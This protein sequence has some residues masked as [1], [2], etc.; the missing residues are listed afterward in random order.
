MS[1]RTILSTDG[2]TEVCPRSLK[3]GAFPSPRRISTYEREEKGIERREAN[4]IPIAQIGGH[5]SAKI[6]V[7]EINSGDSIIEVY[8][9]IHV[10]QELASVFF[11]FGYVP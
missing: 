9:R 10:P 7:K 6:R 11:L 5:L 8:P 3:S 2:T 1:P 4:D